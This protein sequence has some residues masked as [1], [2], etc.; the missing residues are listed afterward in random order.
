MKKH[1]HKIERIQIKMC[2]LLDNMRSL[3]YKEKLKKINLL[4][5]RARRIKHQ[6]LTIFKIMNNDI[7]LSFDDFFQQNNF[8][9]TRGNI[10]KLTLPK[11]RTKTYQNFFT[12]AIIKHWNNLKSSEIKVRSS[13]SFKY[14]I[15]KYF[16][17]A[18]IW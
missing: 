18:K 10:F 11:I 1:E 15:N 14:S 5:L 3:S 9:K 17:R 7:N 2:K 6:L 16:I 12:C 8:N 4:S 13:N